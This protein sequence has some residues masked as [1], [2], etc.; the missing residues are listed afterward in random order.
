MSIIVR[1][2]TNSDSK[3]ILGQ[4]SVFS[5]FFESK[6]Q[7]FSGEANETDLATLSFMINDHLFLVAERE[8]GVLLGLVSGLYS[9]H[10][11]NP[12]IKVLT[13]TFWW[14]DEQHRGTRAGYLLLKEFI[15][16]GREDCQWILMTLEKKS[17]V[18]DEALIKL[19]FKEKEK[20]FLME[21]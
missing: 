11:F 21:V 13:E 4:L 7:L 12:N 5:K 6:Y 8:D 1:K 9:P 17:P 3:W 18:H 19:G 10:L 2:A 14:V 20:I 15:R 16:I